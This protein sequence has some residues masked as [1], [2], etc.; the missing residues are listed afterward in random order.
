MN[1]VGKQ[2]ITD[3]DFLVKHINNN[4]TAVQNLCGQIDILA[5]LWVMKIEQSISMP[6]PALIIRIYHVASNSFA[7]KSGPLARAAIN[8][9]HNY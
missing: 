6:N 9:G 2:L 3:Y 8:E 7:S 5:S 1:F 4:K